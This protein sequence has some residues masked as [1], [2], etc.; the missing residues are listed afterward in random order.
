MLVVPYQA[1]RVNVNPSDN[2]LSVALDLRPDQLPAAPQIQSNRWQMLQNPRFL[3]RARSF[4][5]PRSYTAARPIDNSIAPSVPSA[6][7]APCPPVPCVVFPPCVNSANFD[8]GWTEELDEF[9][10]E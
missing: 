3:E 1:L 7:S 8:P 4:Y 5:Q 6:A 10:M 9:S 2:R